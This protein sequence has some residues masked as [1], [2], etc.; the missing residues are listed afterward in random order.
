MK[1]LWK[2]GGSNRGISWIPFCPDSQEESQFALHSAWRAN[3]DRHQPAAGSA[4]CHA[5]SPICAW[6]LHSHCGPAG[7]AQII[8]DLHMIGNVGASVALDEG[9]IFRQRKE[10]GETAGA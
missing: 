2:F 9:G 8:A 3:G 6:S 1:M 4:H 7:S 5:A 10:H